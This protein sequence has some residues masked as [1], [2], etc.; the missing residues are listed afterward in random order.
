MPHLE[1]RFQ[2]TEGSKCFASIDMTHGYWQIPLDEGSREM[3]SIQTPIGVYTPVRILQGGSDSG[4][5]FQAVTEEKFQAGDVKKL[6]QWID[7][8]LL[9]AKD[10]QELINNIEKFLIVC[11]N[12]NFKVHALKTTLF[13]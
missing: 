7:D 2:D 3:H 5:H 4:N 6:L 11:K 8:F 9:Y 12:C 10:E 1:S 13:S